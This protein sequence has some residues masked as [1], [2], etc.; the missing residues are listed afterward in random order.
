M[1]DGNTSKVSWGKIIAGAAIAAGA[2]VAFA[3]LGASI[4]SLIGSAY[5][6]A[7]NETATVLI[8][9]TAGT[10]EVLSKTVENAGSIGSG[11]IGFITKNTG[12]AAAA[13]AVAGGFIAAASGQGGSVEQADKRS[14]AMEEEMRRVDALMQARMAANGYAPAMAMAGKGRG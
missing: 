10:S 11:I 8:D 1:S 13:A 3:F 2:V 5:V 9:Y 6:A 4:D 14:F 7:Q 12:L